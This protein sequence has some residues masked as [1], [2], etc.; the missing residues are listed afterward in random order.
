LGIVLDTSTIVAHERRRR[1][2]AQLMEE[3]EFLYP[4]QSVA[5]SVMTVVELSHGV[6]RSTDL[7]VAARR[8]AFID[9]LASR[10]EVIPVSLSLARLIGRIE[11]EQAAAGRVIDLADLIIGASALQRN[12]A[13]LTL[14]KK[15]FALIPN[16]QVLTPS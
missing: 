8:Q 13:V 10:L 9:Q 3:L 4:R 14:N 5:I 15:H 11:G 7:Q 16:L 1:S 6:Y 2:I 12:D